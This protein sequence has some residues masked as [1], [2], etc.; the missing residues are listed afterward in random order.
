MIWPKWLVLLW[1]I[2]SEDS[3]RKTILLGPTVS[4][5]GKRTGMDQS[6]IP[7]VLHHAYK[8]SCFAINSQL[9]LARG[10]KPQLKRRRN[11]RC[12]GVNFLPEYTAQIR[13]GNGINSRQPA[14]AQALG[15]LLCPNV[16][17]QYC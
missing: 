12:I 8:T 2:D 17:L 15:L 11:S 9:K 14:V 13:I 6:S 4:F 7:E 16:N 5:V 10:A 1:M 3:C